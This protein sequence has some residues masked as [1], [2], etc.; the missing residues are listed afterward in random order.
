MVG[1]EELRGWIVCGGGGRR[2][3]PRGYEVVE[4]NEN[5]VRCIG[6][7]RRRG[8]EAHLARRRRQ[9]EEEGEGNEGK[10][11]GVFFSAL[12]QKR[13]RRLRWLSQHRCGLV[14]MYDLRGTYVDITLFLLE[15]LKA[16][17]AFRRPEPF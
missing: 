6:L 13:R 4:I 14:A 1:M 5:T 3:G 16:L 7:S 10:V 8:E 9:W 17:P 12:S 2:R 15:L 11:E